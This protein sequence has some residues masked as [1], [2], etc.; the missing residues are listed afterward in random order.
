MAEARSA[1]ARCILRR[2]RDQLSGEVP[3]SWFRQYSRMASE[4]SARARER[5]ADE[6]FSL[7]PSRAAMSLWESPIAFRQRFDHR[8]KHFRRHR[9]GLFPG[10][11]VRNDILHLLHIHQLPGQAPALPIRIEGHVDRDPRHPGIQRSGTCPPE[12]ADN[13]VNLDECVLFQVLRIGRVGNIAATERKN[14]GA[15][16]HVQFP[17]RR[18]V[19]TGTPEGQFLLF[20]HLLNS[21]ITGILRQW[22]KKND[23]SGI[24]LDHPD[25]GTGTDGAELLA[26][27]DAHP[28]FLDRTE[29]AFG[30]VAGAFIDADLQIQK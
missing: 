14:P 22:M 1:A 7:M 24:I 6:L 5:L 16:L 13:A 28:A 4:S 8:R 9:G 27:V 10:G 25:D 23:L 20:H 19:S 3:S 17:A 21:G 18:I 12:T 30:L 2:M 11:F 29:D 26:L 15:V